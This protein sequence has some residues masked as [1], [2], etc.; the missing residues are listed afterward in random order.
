M[1]EPLP[2]WVTRFI[3][4]LFL[5]FLIGVLSQV[6]IWFVDRYQQKRANRE[7]QIQLATETVH[8]VVDTMDTLYSEM[9]YNAWYVA[10][11]M[12]LMPQNYSD[13]LKEMDKEKWA[14]YNEALDGWR[15]NLITNESDMGSFFGLNG[16][17][18]EQ[19]REIVVLFEEAAD[20][21]WQIAY[22]SK[23]GD[24]IIWTGGER[25]WE[26]REKDLTETDQM[27]SKDEFETF[28][29]E[30]RD[31]IQVLVQKLIHCIQLQ[32]VG[33]MRSGEPEYPTDVVTAPPKHHHKH[34]QMHP[35][36]NGMQPLMSDQEV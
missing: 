16:S 24:T 22:A 31:K 2:E 27:M 26:K 25:S 8:R 10:W 11:R 5:S 19:F 14:K 30:V 29:G 33:T 35:A 23:A 13:T 4:P 12:A 1:S 6:I 21:L 3:L 28:F 36:V 7:Q 9:K 32:Y 34:D 17:E 20:K 18:V 15:K